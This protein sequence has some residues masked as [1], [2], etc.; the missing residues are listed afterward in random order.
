MPR[1]PIGLGLPVDGGDSR[2]PDPLVTAADRTG[3]TLSALDAPE[4]V[5][6][7]SVAGPLK[8]FSGYGE[9]MEV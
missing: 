8:S 6:S 4:P 1:T 5:A 7:S 2:A 3:Q 9:V